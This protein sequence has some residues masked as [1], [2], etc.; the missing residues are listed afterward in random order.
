MEE[1]VRRGF[2]VRGQVQAVGFRWWTWRNASRL[3]LR[4]TVRNRPDGSVEVRVEGSR[5]AVEELR[6][7][8]ERGPHGARVSSL[9]DFEPEGSLPEDFEIVS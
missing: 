5:E 8:L 6:Q 3:G 9:E 7:L 4:G 2:T 1:T